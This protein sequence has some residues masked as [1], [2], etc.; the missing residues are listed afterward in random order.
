VGPSG[1][2][3]R[4]ALLTAF[5]AV[6]LKPSTWWLA[7]IGVATWSAALA[8]WAVRLR[9]TRGWVRLHISFMCGSYLAVVTAFLVNTWGSPF[10]W[11]LPTVIGSPL[12]AV[13]AARAGVP[14]RRRPQ[15]VPAAGP[16][17]SVAEH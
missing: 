15:A 5:G 9:R 2:N 13:T 16:T 14:T 1:F 12:I 17:G 10:A 6:A 4:G 3:G 8:G 7:A 11:I